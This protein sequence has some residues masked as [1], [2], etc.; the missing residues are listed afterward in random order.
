MDR[1]FAYCER[2]LDASFLAEPLNA[3]S[4]AAFILAAVAAARELRGT[5]AG[6][7]LAVATLIVIVVVIGFGSFLFHTYATRWAA[8]ADVIPIFV[9]M[10]AYLAFALSVYCGL[11]WRWVAVA[12]VGFVWALQS[13]GTIECPDLFG[14]ADVSRGRCLNGTL[15]YAPALVAMLATGALLAYRRH[16][17]AMYLVGAGLLFLASM[18][19]RSLDIALCGQTHVLGQPRGT[20]AMWHLLNAATLYILLL[21]AIRHGRRPGAIA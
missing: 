10:L 13:A 9:F 21:A 4:N 19:F 5:G 14:I 2:G 15:R 17:A 1:I 7:P 6:N 16:P 12:L 20:H 3:L 8:L 18:T 11:G